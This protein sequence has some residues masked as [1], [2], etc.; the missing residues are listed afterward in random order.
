M[1]ILDEVAASEDVLGISELARRVGL[2]KSTVHGLVAALTEEGLLAPAGESKGYH[3]GPKLVDLGARARD[4]RL[5]DIAE[6]E[7]KRLA[8]DTGET[9]LFGQLNRLSVRILAA[10]HSPRLLNLSAAIGSSVPLLAGALGKAYAASMPPPLTRAF[11][12]R[13]TLPPYT[14]RSITA[15]DVYLQHVAAARERGYA[16]E[17]GEYLSGIA[18]V[19]AT[20]TWMGR[21]Y[22]VWAVGI[23]ANHSDEELHCLGRAVRDAERQIA[24]QLDHPDRDRA[25]RSA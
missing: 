18:A 13:N 2:S 3:L 20:F 19:A 1:R 15:T 9:V 11:L 23:D 24:H 16:T 5:L 10:R 25:E 14:D 17:R 12:H 21:T 4:Q 22:F 6:A 7:L 8:A